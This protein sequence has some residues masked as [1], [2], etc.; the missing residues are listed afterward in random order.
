MPL[1]IIYNPIAESGAVYQT[2]TGLTVQIRP[3][4]INTFS[5]AGGSIAIPSNAAGVHYI[6][7][8]LFRNVAMCLPRNLHRGWIPLARVVVSNTAVISM[9]Q[10]API[11]P[12]CRLPR[13]VKRLE[14][15]Q[16]INVL[17]MG[18]SLAE[19]TTTSYW[20]GML[21]NSAAK[22]ADYRLPGTITFNNIA[23]GGTPNQYQLAQLGFGS[24][25]AA[26][27]YGNSGYPASV[28]A[29]A[30][31]NGRS[32]IFTGVDLV[33]I[34]LLANGGDYRLESIEPIIRNLRKMGI[35]V[36]LTT[37]NPVGYP[38][39]DYT[40]LMAAGLYVDG[41]EVRR[42][43]D[44][45]KCEF[46]DTAAYV[47]DAVLRYPGGNV[48][49]DS[50]HMYIATPA[51][52]LAVPS[53]GYEIYARAIRSCIPIDCP[54][55]G[56][57]VNSYDFNS[58]V[59]APF[60][61]Y[62]PTGAN[63]SVVNGQLVTS[64]A[65]ATVG[66][67]GV[68][69]GPSGSL[70][71][72]K[73]G[74]T[75]RIQGNVISKPASS[76]SIGLQGGGAGWGSDSPQRTVTGPFDVTVTANRDILNGFLLFLG[77]DSS[78]GNGDTFV[79]DDLIITVNSSY[80]G[81]AYT[82]MLREYEAQTLPK[83]RIVTDMKTPGDAFVILPKDER[84]LN[85]ASNQG[86][87]GASPLG[88]GS[89]AR[90]FSS[91]VGVAEDLLTL[92]TGQR[93]S[94]AA[95]GVVGFGLIYYSLN[96][97]PSVTIDVY[98]NNTFAKTLTIAAQTLSQEIYLPVY[99]P[100]EH[101]KAAASPNNETIDLRVTSGTLRIAALVALTSEHDVYTPE[102]A[103]KMGTWGASRVNGGSPNMPGLAT[104][105][106]NA[107]AFFRCPETG[108]RVYWFISSKP[109]SKTTRTWSGRTMTDNEAQTGVNNT[110]TIGG[111]VGPGDLHYVRLLETQ[112]AV[113]QSTNGYG[114]HF[115]AIIVVN[116][117]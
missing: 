110:K 114:L 78:A 8:D 66:Q 92:T 1:P 64:K 14:L 72:V 15:G 47:A 73:N 59:A 24:S 62:G 7:V 117:R 105:E 22:A 33:V 41:P 63:I 106:I 79:L 70:T 31:P 108:N 9:T 93:A 58:G 55:Y 90:R 113:D 51:G 82:S 17:V 112:A 28:N 44:Q 5:Y 87:L 42:L 91:T 36:I 115:G 20:S 38:F 69:A 18:S 101:A 39:A 107:Q 11:L 95:L 111:H 77:T 43:A 21:F 88:S 53:G 57:V 37:D 83:S 23:L 89:F 96:G 97:D 61:T 52:R 99:T 6:G 56:T 85:L 84:H 103:A 67:W 19:G 68:A 75:V 2:A 16:A 81:T 27:D 40:A 30:P 3:F 45:Y 49:R 71:P 60:T 46:A 98:K 25:F 76:I 109:N 116:D 94:I 86:T 102:A 104:D 50:T 80:E 35:E 4:S 34:T 10:I 74:D 12:T 48:Y 54:V 26:L 32:S 100:T 13:L 65:S 29:K